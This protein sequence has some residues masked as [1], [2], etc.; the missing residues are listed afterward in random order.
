MSCIAASPRYRKSRSCQRFHLHSCQ[1]FQMAGAEKAAVQRLWEVPPHPLCAMHTVTM[2][3]RHLCYARVSKRLTSDCHLM[4]G[5]SWGWSWKIVWGLISLTV[6]V[7]T[8]FKG[9]AWRNHYLHQHFSS[10]GPA[11][12]WNPCPSPAPICN[13]ECPEILGEKDRRRW[14][15]ICKAAFGLGLSKMPFVFV[16][17]LL[18]FP[19]KFF[20]YSFSEI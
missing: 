13:C 1:H 11:Q 3:H 9:P 6:R 2:V 10:P 20:K 19:I 16:L 7:Q 8:E 17:L 18:S 14:I 5:C 15:V 4:L 12:T